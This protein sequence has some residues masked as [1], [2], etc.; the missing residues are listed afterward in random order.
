M[1][2]PSPRQRDALALVADGKFYPDL[3]KEDDGWHARWR[4]LG[5]DN[6]WVDEYVRGPSVTV[7]SEDAEDQRH[8]TLHDAWAMALRSRTGLVRWDDAECA[9]FAAELAEW[10]G[11]GSEDVE[12]RRA[13]CFSFHAASDSSEN[14]FTLSCPRP[15]GRAQYRALGQAV[16]VWGGL[17]GLRS[18]GAS[19][20][21]ALSK[22]E[23]EDFI[24]RGARELADAGYSVSGVDLAATVAAV[25][26]IDGDA[27]DAPRD[28]EKKSVRLKIKVAGEEVSAEEIRFL[29]EQNSTLVF[30]RDR[31]I[32][33]DRGILR[34]ALRALEKSEKT[35]SNPLSFAL[36]IG[37][38]G[39]MEVE[40]V[41]ADG[42]IL[43]LLNRL[44]QSHDG[45]ANVTRGGV[46]VEI[47]GFEGALRDYQSRG[48]DWISF[49]TD[50]GFGALLADD[51]GLGKTIQTIAWILRGQGSGVRDQES[52]VRGQ[53][54]RVLVVAP[55]TLLSNWRHEFAKF[56]PSLRVYVHQGDMRHVGS[57]FK[58]AAAEA[59]VVVTSYALIV[60]D[61]REFAEVEWDGIVLD[62][63]QAIKNPD[64]HA[65][66]AIR[67]LGVRRRL[68]LTGTP[69]ENGVADIWSLEE[70]LNP[71]LLGDRKSFADRFVKPLATDPCSAQ[72]KKL[73]RALEPFVLRRLKSDPAV[74][75]ELGEKREI[76]EYC[77]LAP[78]ERAEYER[79]LADYRAGE[80][81]Q[82]DIF[83][84][85]TR[86][87]LACDG[88]DGEAVAGGKVDRLV[89]LVE[90]IFENGESVLIF[91]QYAKVGEALK[92]MLER[93]FSQPIAFLHG[94]LSAA[95]REEQ[96]ALFGGTA[97]PA[98]FVLSLRAGG[99]GLNLTKA[100]HVIHFDRW[101]NPAVEGQATDRAHRIGQEKTVFVHVFVTEGT[102]EERVEEILERKES[103]AG[104][105]K[106]GE[107]L[108]NAIGL[109]NA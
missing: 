42:G 10:H 103:L 55:L 91:S 90:T 83:A 109:D 50:N 29:L 21:A 106:D 104:L 27:A 56:A 26:E 15:K 4:A 49:L 82:G 63:A 18:D 22:G 52:V 7:L 67:A 39:R 2:Q 60:R 92:K 81:R 58:K 43:G 65:A 100:T 102:V 59:D 89:E 86:L 73:R 94:G 1:K 97:G 77:A 76:R 107:K 3:V 25:A 11:G 20:S 78:A 24:R 54:G 87:K 66:R 32:E 36:G 34:E 14:A 108:W 85:L 33:V 88:F 19:L 64:T 8:E 23:A 44:R 98:A 40:E 47:P 105:L 35:K 37:A 70:F 17:R 53:V 95:Q 9:A 75:G 79:A 30:F 71:G 57:G 31:W 38:V 48:V 28:D 69:I 16:C 72:G 41:L 84:L 46:A 74:A 45:A 6:E 51:M 96:I 68:A 99:F 12:A 62:E 61:H 5:A 101:W 13:L 93:R 80:R